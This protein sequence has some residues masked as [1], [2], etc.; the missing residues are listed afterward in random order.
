[1]SD[2][3]ETQAAPATEASA[4]A[5]AAPV[6]SAPEAGRPAEAPATTTPEPTAQPQFDPNQVS[7]WKRDAERYA[8]DRPLV[9]AAISAGFKTPESFQTAAQLQAIANE[10]GLDLNQ[11][12]SV[13]QG[14]QPAQEQ[15]QEQKFLTP[16]DLVSVLDQRD[17]NA[18]HTSAAAAM[19]AAMSTTRNEIAQAVGIDAN[20]P[21]LALIVESLENKAL[22]N[23]LYPEG[24]PLRDSK[25]KP[26]DASQY[27]QIKE[28]AIKTFAAIR[29]QQAVANANTALASVPTQPSGNGLQ[30]VPGEGARRKFNPYADHTQADI[31]D[32]EDILARTTGNTQRGVVVNSV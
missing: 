10:R 14:K 17:A 31:A 16:D 25:L 13:L 15:P 1:V 24:H 20:D 2:S 3:P 30:S 9:D 22:E 18:A 32:A 28:Q 6:S 4:P 7:Q 21:N 11:L 27:A 8:G 12:A 23:N 26:L 19:E 5:P 29:G